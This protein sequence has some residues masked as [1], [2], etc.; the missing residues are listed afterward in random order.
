MEK[1]ES[2]YILATEWHLAMFLWSPCASTKPGTFTYMP[3]EKE[4]AGCVN[5]KFHSKFFTG[6]IVQQEEPNGIRMRK[7]FLGTSLHR[8]LD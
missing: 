3:R 5:N 8:D 2:Q 1:W 7:T 6:S 4:K